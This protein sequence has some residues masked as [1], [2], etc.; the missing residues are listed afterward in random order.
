MK[1]FKRYFF[2]IVLVFA[3]QFVIN[4]NP[5]QAE[6][7][8]D[9]GL[10]DATFE[11]NPSPCAVFINAT[12]G[13]VFNVTGGNFVY[14]KTTDG[15]KTWAAAVTFM[16]AK[17]S[18]NIAVW[19]DRWTPNDNAG[20]RIHIAASET[21]TDD[22][23][24]H[25]LDTATDTLRPA[26]AIAVRLGASYALADGGPTICKSTEGYLY[27]A[28]FSSTA[29]H[30]GVSRSV[31]GGD[32]W[33]NITPGFLFDDDD[34]HCQLLPL[35]GGDVLCIYNDM[36]ASQGLWFVWEEDTD[37]WSASATVLDTWTENATYNACFGATCIRN[38]SSND[39]YL[40]AN[41]SP[42]NAS[43]DLK[44]YKFTDSTH[45]WAVLTDILTDTNGCLDVKMFRDLSNGDLYAIYV[46]G[47]A[48]NY[49]QVFSRK[50]TDGGNTWGPETLVSYTSDDHKYVRTNLMSADIK[51]IFWYNDDL[52]D[53]LCDARYILT[54]QGLS[55]DFDDPNNWSP[56]IAPTNA[57]SLIIP[58]VGSG[59]YPLI[60]STTVGA[61][62]NC[63]A[64]TINTGANI[65]LNGLDLTCYGPV[66]IE[67][68]G[69]LKIT[70]GGSQFNIR[71]SY[72]NY[73]TLTNTEGDVVLQGPGDGP[74][75]PAL[76]KTNCAGT[77]KSFKFLRIPA[78]ARLSDGVTLEVTGTGGL[79]FQLNG[80]YLY[81]GNN[82]TL[83]TYD[84]W[85]TTTGKF[86][87]DTSTVILKGTGNIPYESDA[88]LPY[89]FYNLQIDGTFSVAGTNQY[90]YNHLTITENG[91]LAA[92]TYNIYGYGNWVNNGSFNASSA[93]VQLI[94]TSSSAITGTTQFNIVRFGDGTNAKTITLQ[95]GADI[96]ATNTLEI[97]A[98]AVLN[99]S[100]TGGPNATLTIPSGCMLTIGGTWQPRNGTFIWQKDDTQEQLPALA[101]GFY[102]LI[103]DPSGSGN[104]TP[105]GALNIGSDFYIKSGTFNGGN[106]LT[107]TIGGDWIQDGAFSSGT[108]TIIFNGADCEILKS[109]SNAGSL[110]FNSLTSSG[111]LTKIEYGKSI[112][113]TGNF[114]ITA[115]TFNAGTATVFTISTWTDSG[116]F[117]AGTSEVIWKGGQIPEQSGGNA[118]EDFYSLTVDGTC[119]LDG[120]N[121]DKTFTINKHL[122]INSTKS[123]DAG[124]PATPYNIELKG[125]FQLDGSFTAGNS[126]LLLNGTVKQ[127]L[128]GSTS[129]TINNLEINKTTGDANA[130]TVEL[131]FGL[132]GTDLTINGTTNILAGILNLGSTADTVV[133]QGNITV[134]N[135]SGTDDSIISM[136]GGVTLQMGN[137]TV[138]EVKTPDGILE[139]AQSGL[140][141]LV[142][143]TNPGTNFY[144]IKIAG[145][146]RVNGLQ[147]KSIG[148]AGTF[149]DP[150]ANHGVTILTTA[151]IYSAGDT[152][153]DQVTF[154]DIQGSGTRDTYLRVFRNA[155]SPQLS[156]E[157]NKHKYDDGAVDANADVNV[158]LN[159]GS[160]GSTI[161][162]SMSSGNKGGTN[163]ETY[164]MRDDSSSPGDDPDPGS[165]QWPINKVWTGL[166][167]DA[168]NVDGNWKLEDGSPTE[169][170]GGSDSITIPSNP[171]SN[172]DKWPVISANASVKNITLQSPISAVPTTVLSVNGSWIFTIYGTWTIND[173]TNCL[174]DPGTSTVDYAGSSGQG[175]VAT[176]Y[177]NL[178]LSNTSGLQ[179]VF[180]PIII[181][182]DCTILGGVNFIATTTDVRVEGNWNNYGTFSPGNCTIKFQGNSGGQE[183]N[184]TGGQFRHLEFS[185]SESKKIN[186]TTEVLGNV[187]IAGGATVNATDQSAIDIKIGGNFTVTGT[188][189]AGLSTIIFNGAAAQ[190]LIR[191][192]GTISFNNLKLLNT[193]TSLKLVQQS[194]GATTQTITISTSDNAGNTNLGNINIGTGTTL[195]ATNDIINCGG[196]W[197]VNGSFTY[198][199]STVSLNASAAQAIK[200]NSSF[201]TLNIANSHSSDYVTFEGNITV[202]NNLNITDGQ[203][204]LDIG[205]ALNHG[206]ADNVTIAGGAKLEM[207]ISNLVIG[208]SS[209]F[210]DL[211]INGQFIMSSTGTAAPTLKL[212]GDSGTVNYTVEAN[213]PDITVNGT[214]QTLWSNGAK[215]LIQAYNPIT[216]GPFYCFAVKASGI[217]NV[218]GLVI[219]SAYTYDSVTTIF[220][221]LLLEP[222]AVC[223]NLN[224]VDYQNIMGGV[225]GTYRGLQFRIASGTYI[226]DGCSFDDT[227]TYNVRTDNGTPTINMTNAGGTRGVSTYEDQVSGTIN[228]IANRI[229]NGG[230]T[231]I[232]T[233]TANWDGALRADT[234]DETAIINRVLPNGYNP[235]VRTASYTIR[236][237]VIKNSNTVF[238]DD[239]GGDD[240][241]VSGDVIM[242]PGSGITMK[243]FATCLLY[244]QGNWDNQGGI[245]DQQSTGGIIYL[246][247]VGKTISTE[248]GFR[249]L[250]IDTA[251]TSYTLV[252]GATVAISGT[253]ASY[254]INATAML[255]GGNNTNP[256]T[257]KASVWATNLNRFDAGNSKFV[258]MGTTNVPLETY[259][260]L[261]IG[262]QSDGYNISTTYAYSAD[263]LINRHL[264]VDAGST[265]TLNQTGGTLIVKGNIWVKE[266]ATLNLNNATVRL[267]GDFIIDGV[268]N[269]GTSTVIFGGG[270]N[271]KI[272]S[273]VTPPSLTLND[274]QITPTTIAEL[275]MPITTTN[276]NS[277]LASPHGIIK[278]NSYQLVIT[279]QWNDSDA[280]DNLT[281][282]TGTVY[283]YGTSA[284]I[285]NETWYD[286]KVGA[287]SADTTYTLPNN[288]T[289]K[290]DITFNENGIINSGGFAL[291]VARHWID[292]GSED[293]FTEG[294]GTV[295]F[296][297]TV[298]Q[299][300]SGET[301][302]NLII[303]NTGVAVSVI[304]QG[305]L[306]V[307][308]NL[309]ISNGTLDFGSGFVGGNKHT[310][311]GYCYIDNGKLK[312]NTS[313]I[314]I[315]GLLRI[316][317]GSVGSGILD[318]TANSTDDPDVTATG[319]V[320]VTSTGTLDV[321]GS[322]A[323]IT[324]GGNWV[325]TGSFNLGQSKVILSGDGN[326]ITTTGTS[327]F[328][329]LHINAGSVISASTDCSITN[330]LVV[331]GQF[332]TANKT[333]AVSGNI[334]NGGIIYI[335]EAAAAGTLDLEGD[336][337]GGSLRFINGGSSL[338]YF[339]GASF[340]PTDLMASNGT[341]I[342]DNTLSGQTIPSYTYNNIRI[343]KSGQTATAG[344]NL[345]I[346]GTL[347]VSSGIFD[348]DDGSARVHTIGAIS[349]SGTVKMDLASTINV[350]GNTINASQVDIGIGT[351]NNAVNY[352]NTGGTTTLGAGLLDING[353]LT[354]G[355]IDFNNTTGTL[356]IA[357]TFTPTTLN[358]DAGTIIFDGTG[359]AIPAESY[360]NLKTGSINTTYTLGGAIQVK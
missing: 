237:L 338:L 207:G 312:L 83:I 37:T 15:G 329:A 243:D 295:Q 78:Y 116:A 317:D 42:N 140:I 262:S 64:L 247:G 356:R 278:L 35:A 31:N 13:Y 279:G 231:D 176:T 122:K 283:F 30:R 224:N 155:S 196:N 91:S 56:A 340:A 308:N 84:S 332:G 173:Y 327:D 291:Y 226:F 187:S 66:V 102:K 136:L 186:G 28:C 112:V 81:A 311:G 182:N 202:N 126:K 179:M 252:D 23:W 235:R 229:W 156:L 32:A 160:T 341:I 315:T 29:A 347:N 314:S 138:L 33:V 168:W 137:G 171:D 198:D 7:T 166:V 250:S 6:V 38:T 108:S 46:R 346:N 353:N 276:I 233:N 290:N 174:F 9:A 82:T 111:T 18:G 213:R 115:G 245:L 145:K 195:D 119:S 104:V 148:S 26:G 113:V 351:Y 90:V 65:Q 208:N 221:A 106:V 67:E 59:N 68:G 296:N 57:Y 343:L 257:L 94:G 190:E 209:V 303:T 52:N 271:Q 181:Y 239:D 326:Y 96:K 331:T 274:I 180:E 217:I 58:Q 306:T 280:G 25:Y 246:R 4:L 321:T 228:W 44:A 266:G 285:P 71:V 216:P 47:W 324:A 88:V 134:G 259:Y 133:S 154:D 335:G 210:G 214:F 277:G 17:T 288:T 344:G 225:S 19:Y 93:E 293:N 41:N 157:F 201:Y 349:N 330:N 36:T 254:F 118:H 2:A 185:G 334:T 319:G 151:D 263:R 8:I 22:T 265:L 220:S 323:S 298:Q 205:T 359:Q 258:W 307:S 200:T 212:H 12:T 227:C 107:H 268:V 310:I 222:G 132:G 249:K 153:F 110:T 10:T 89:E 150:G 139:S 85:G 320:N 170:P 152:Y 125:N 267:E 123:L 27:I 141:P 337:T 109:P 194:G 261:Q 117:N 236:N 11:Y 325:R 188:F 21:G 1:Q 98:N 348:G 260:D 253:S 272:R 256:A 342:F 69:E 350:T 5:L 175:V 248:T 158:Y 355:T 345:A 270:I 204:K 163:A 54:W 318:M 336:F 34:D 242:E 172:P 142:T 120:A 70:N 143:S 357:G 48:E 203:V 101:N 192:A 127:T 177:Y 43:G 51:R 105:N 281:E 39:I 284:T 302:N 193:G 161:I 218:N 197:L 354:G 264:I 322:S 244:V 309:T 40:S 301:F 352:T 135:A 20:T 305:K 360:Y 297:G 63:K 128:N 304:A 169:A 149:T 215:P 131:A 114:N 238:I 159:R 358:E 286:L 219:D 24:Y 129:L 100:P 234:T 189:S 87:K 241:T 55:R 165:I 147:I 79:G 130:K 255:Y 251:G 62:Q 164:D 60:D 183:Q 76:V 191:P 313:S 282:D 53:L 292:N 124:S 3:F 99:G 74:V 300:V 103:V 273:T 206:V 223:S 316:G 339:S 86:Y 289:V 121:S 75:A 240:L 328:Y 146:T 49:N 92:S 72:E 287:P 184:I 50:S 61:N 167:S 333:V 77:G 14:R 299:N 230:A 162:Q 232:W 211:S 199:G 178:Q 80:G 45:T 269:G 16:A 275:N 73:G 97:K 144:Y 95:S 294:A